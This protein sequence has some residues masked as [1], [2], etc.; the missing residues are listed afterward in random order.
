M[1][2][3]P[4]QLAAV[5]CGEVVQGG[6]RRVEASRRRRHPE[7]NNHPQMFIGAYILLVWV[8]T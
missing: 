1:L 5:A 3:L 7:V 4:G 2:S 8:F 6:A